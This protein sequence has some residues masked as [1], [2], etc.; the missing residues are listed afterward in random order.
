[1]TMID[2][3]GRPQ[4]DVNGKAYEA[5]DDVAIEATMQGEGEGGG[6]NPLSRLMRWAGPEMP[7]I[8]EELTEGALSAIGMRVVRHYEIDKQSR[9]HW[10]TESNKALDMAMQRT[11]AKNYPWEKASNVIYPLL[12]EAADQF[13]AR[14]YPAII[15]NNNVVKGVVFGPD[16]GIPIENPEAPGQQLIDPRNGKPAWIV[17]PGAK[18]ERADRIGEHMSYQLLEEQ[19]EWEVETDILVSVLPIVG[20]EFRKTYYDPGQHRNVSCRVAAKSLVINYWAKSMETAPR[21]TEELRLYPDEIKE[22]QLSDYYIEHDFGISTEENANG[23]ED[24]PHVMLEQHRRLDLDGDGYGEPY[25]VTVHRDTMKVVRIV[26]RYDI[27]DIE[28]NGTKILRIPGVAYY[29]KYD[30]LPNKEG[31]IYGQGLA[32]SLMPINEAVNT[33]LNM[34]IDAGHLQNT[35]G[36]FIGKGLS[37]HSG[38]IKF[39]PGEYKIVNSAGMT[40]RDSIVPLVHPGPSTVLLTL[41]GTLV[42]AGKN[43]SSVKDVMTGDIKA[44]TMSPTVFLALIEQGLKVFTAIYKRIHRSLKSEFDKQYRLNR[45]YLDDQASYR[46]GDQWKQI[47]RQDYERMTG[48]EPISDP[49]MVV[50]PQKMARG[51]FLMAFANDPMMNGLEIRRRAL[52]AASIDQIDTLLQEKP[53]PNP[54]AIA[55]L[56]SLELEKIEKKSRAILNMASAIKQLADADKV[57]MEQFDLWAQTQLAMMQGVINDIDNPGGP[58]GPAGNN[59]TQPGDMGAVEAPSGLE[60]AAPVPPGLSDVAAPGSYGTMGAG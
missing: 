25:I 46:V 59:G 42:E 58:S 54:E 47:S 5:D 21:I 32:Q 36:G 27:E 56:A 13:A 39:K 23:D 14:A 37:M 31:G 34:L 8:A 28:Y 18:R 12:T 19:P 53:A 52:E 15:A 44:Q 4:G 49:T 57:V 11:K 48:V 41:L 7:N 50:D 30:F 40:I 29:T 24:A 16:E 10:L 2:F 35:G 17:P 51:Q 33:T 3:Q 55:K 60:G 26:A 9:E 45:L 43:I 38:T 20:C 1:M 6:S 22:R